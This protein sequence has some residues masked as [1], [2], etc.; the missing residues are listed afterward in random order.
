MDPSVFRDPPKSFRPAPFWSWNDDLEDDELAWQV[1]DMKAKG[2]GGYFMHSRDGLITEYLSEA[3][4]QRVATCI[5]VGREQD[6]ESWLYDEDRWPSGFAG[7]LVPAQDPSYRAC[8]LVA[9]RIAAT[10]AEE[11]ARDAD[12]LAVFAVRRAADGGIAEMRRLAPGTGASPDD[13]A[14]EVRRFA[15]K[16]MA[17]TNRFNG[18]AYVDLLNPEVTE[19]FLRSTYRLGIVGKE[20]LQFWKL[21][22]WA[23]FRRPAHFQ[24]AVMLAISGYHFRKVCEQHVR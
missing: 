20:R 14:C 19:A 4:M 1:R 3:W 22:I 16:R 6:M 10:D 23:T 12:T 9:E 17:P 8:G 11:A 24:T 18:E 21:L 13:G 2:F 15:V 7:G 5:R